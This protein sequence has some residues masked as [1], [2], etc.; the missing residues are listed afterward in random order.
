MQI[1]KILKKIMVSDASEQMES[2]EL[3]GESYSASLDPGV[4]ILW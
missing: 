2:H 4:R 1:L 3:L